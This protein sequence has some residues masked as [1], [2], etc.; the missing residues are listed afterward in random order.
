L[1][2]SETLKGT[3]VSMGRHS[4]RGSAVRSLTPLVH[5]DVSLGKLLLCE[6]EPGSGEQGAG[7]LGDGGHGELGV[8]CEAAAGTGGVRGT[9]AVGT[10]RAASGVSRVQFSRPM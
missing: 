10:D 7:Q 1:F 6:C 4:I 5:V 3:V 9:E 8:G 2:L